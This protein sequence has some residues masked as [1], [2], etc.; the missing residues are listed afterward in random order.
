MSAL[1]SLSLWRQQAAWLVQWLLA[2]LLLWPTL[3]SARD[4]IT[5]RAWFEDTS[6][7]LQW[8]DVRTQDFTPYEGLLS[9]GYGLSAIW[10]RLR[11]DP[12]TNPASALSEQLVLRIRLSYMDDVQL[13]DPLAPATDTAGSNPPWSYRSLNRN[14]LLPRGEAPRDVYLRLQSQGTRTKAIEA[15]TLEE[16]LEKDRQQ[17]AVYAIY[18]SV[19]LVFLLWTLLHWISSREQV[20]GIFAFKQTLAFFWSLSLL[21]YVRW[22]LGEDAP[23]FV[24]LM[25]VGFTA[26]SAYFDYSLF[27]EYQPPRWALRVLLGLIALLPLETV[28]ILNGQISTALRINMVGTLLIVSW[29]FVVAWLARPAQGSQAPAMPHRALVV[30]YGII[31]VSIAVTA[32]MLLG[33]FHSAELA[34]HALQIHGLLTGAIMVIFLQVRAQRMAQRQSQALTDLAVAQENAR[35]EQ[36][37]RQQQ[38]KL[39]EEIRQLAFHDGLTHLPNRRLLLECLQLAITQ[40]QRTGRHSALLFMDL[41]N[42]KPLNDAYGHYVG[43]LLLIEVAQRLRQCVRTC[44]TVSRFGGDEF[45]L[46]L[47]DFST[48]ASTARQQ[49]EVVAEKILAS[50]GQPYRLQADKN[51]ATRTVEHRCSASIGIQLFTTAPDSISSLLDQAD[52]AMYAAKAAGRS[53]LRFYSEPDAKSLSD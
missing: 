9:R 11:I 20:I 31:F 18:L 19:L 8:E 44:D 23:H 48:E 17:E 16:A 47:N 10:I 28:L 49:T 30:F 12:A 15:L 21:G 5:A 22:I 37:H 36:I 13:F 7:Q 25:V 35:Q 53:T 2:G 26:A 43:D 4:H 38:E 3:A 42:F 1:P 27:R 51:D 34:L 41:D 32:L 50:L 24:A 52:A 14:F 39:L 33:V 29:D 6:G 40:N 46:L 45:V